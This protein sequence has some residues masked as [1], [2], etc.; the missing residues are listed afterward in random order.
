MSQR[1]SSFL[2]HFSPKKYA[3][4]KTVTQ[5]QKTAA[6]QEP[7]EE[8]EEVTGEDDDEKTTNSIAPQTDLRSI[9]LENNLK[10]AQEAKEAREKAE[11]AHKGTANAEKHPGRECSA[12]LHGSSP[13]G[14]GYCR[15]MDR[16]CGAPRMM[17]EKKLLEAHIKHGV[18]A[19]NTFGKCPKVGDGKVR[20][21]NLS[22]LQEELNAELERY[23]AQNETKRVTGCA[24][25]MIAWRGLGA[26]RARLRRGYIWSDR[27]LSFHSS[28]RSCQR[29]C[30][31]DSHRA[32]HAFRDMG[33]RVHRAAGDQ[34][35]ERRRDAGGEGGEDRRRRVSE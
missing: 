24:T 27:C 29:R 10:E 31:C 17:S 18:V 20:E 22:R 14:E 35:H 8:V 16:A 13:G 21:A 1:I 23:K 30:G 6:S 7:Q 2:L 4:G 3:T 15:G 25:A 19:I 12:D 9:V 32:W 28:V 34:L 5:T 33:I 26:L 11:K